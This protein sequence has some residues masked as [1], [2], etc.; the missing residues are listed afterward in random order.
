MSAIF[1]FL[2]NLL[3]LP[4]RLLW[5]LVVT[6]LVIGGFVLWFGFLFG[7]V[8]AVV[9]VLIFAPELFLLP[10]ALVALYVPLWGDC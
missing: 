7:S 3:F 5:D 10:L 6:G 1:C 2:G 9:L 4:V 8:V